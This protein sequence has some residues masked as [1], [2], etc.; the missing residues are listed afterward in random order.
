MAQIELPYV[1]W[2]DG[3]PRFEPGR[4]ERAAGWKGQDLRHPGN[5]A[6]FNLAEA[7]GWALARLTEIKA[8]RASGRRLKMPAVRRAPT[9]DNLVEAFLGSAELKRLAP[10]TQS[11]YR[12][13]ANALRYRPRAATDRAPEAM[14]AR[15]PFADM[16][17]AAVGKPEVKAF[18]EYLVEARGLTMARQIIMT[19]S[20]AWKWGTLQP[21]WRLGDNPCNKI[22]LP[23]AAP[24][25]VV[26]EIE[27]V[28]AFVAKADAIGEPAIADAVL[29]A[30]FTGQRQADVLAFTSAH[31]EAGAIRLVQQKTGTR[32]ELPLLP[33][34]V[35]RLELMAKRREARGLQAET[36]VIDDRTGRPFKRHTFSHR[37][38]DVRALVAPA[39]PAIAGRNFQDLRD[40]LLTWL[41]RSG[42]DMKKIAGVSG[43][44]M[45]SIAQVLPHYVAIGTSDAQDAMALL[46]TWMDKKGMAL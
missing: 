38:A 30:L 19:L 20:A 42:A 31:I 36:L 40:T 10:T 14:R 15:E 35:A 41:H 45:A 17:A 24:R 29:L 16:P 18:F 23:K 25:V 22:D 8:Q 7:H 2:R 12:A 11:D 27:E 37:F 5:G 39:L 34:L 46:Q 44:A 33:T 28:R 32:V 9:I 21:A 13:K 43:H 6:W 3:R 26:W 1:K 4:R